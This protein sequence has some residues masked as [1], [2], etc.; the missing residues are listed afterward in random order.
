ML[1]MGVRFSARTEDSPKELHRL[2]CIGFTWTS[3]VSLEPPHGFLLEIGR[4]LKLF[5]G[6]HPIL[7]EAQQRL[8]DGAFPRLAVAPTPRAAWLLT[9]AGNDQPP[10]VQDHARLRKVLAELPVAV[11]EPTPR[12]VRSLETLGVQRLHDLMALPRAG[13]RRRGLATL[14]Q[15]LA[16]ALGEVPEPREGIDPPHRYAARRTL[17]VAASTGEGALAAVQE[18]IRELAAVLR[19]A[20]RAVERLEVALEHRRAPATRFTVGFLE[21]TRDEERLR[22]VIGERL[23]QARVAFPIEA[24]ALTTPPFV[25]FHARTEALPWGC[26]P[27][28]APLLERLNARLGPGALGSPRLRRHPRPEDAWAEVPPQACR[29]NTASSPSDAYRPV[30]LLPRPKRLLESGGVP[31]CNG[32]LRLIRGPERIEGGW[33]DGFDAARDYYMAV[34]QHGSRLWIFRECRAPHRWYLHGVF[35]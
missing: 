6:I 19:T 2:G 4:S 13:S 30:W 26:R 25:E 7:E 10:V 8:S 29:D 28:S 1:W 15:A 18:L 12:Q 9:G 33:W 24:I 21:P 34:N 3:M 11:L 16:Q 22:T 17:P 35:S 14:L 27:S 20:D 32:V 31:C 23:H 5:G